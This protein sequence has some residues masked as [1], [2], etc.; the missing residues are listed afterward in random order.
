MRRRH[1]V[2][3]GVRA[4]GTDGFAPGVPAG[5]EASESGAVA[6]GFC[7]AHQVCSRAYQPFASVARP[8]PVC[9]SHV[10]MCPCA[11]IVISFV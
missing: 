7:E 4:E 2:D 10:V 8:T 6:R 1:H 3:R 5:F 11:V 9:V